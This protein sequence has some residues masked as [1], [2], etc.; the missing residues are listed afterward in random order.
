MQLRFIP[1][2]SGL[3]P[4]TD[5]DLQP[6]TGADG[7]YALRSVERPG[8]RLFVLD[9]ARYLPGYR[10]ELPAVLP[11]AAGAE[12]GH[13]SAGAEA[14]RTSADGE[15]GHTNA[16][17][18]AGHTSSGAAAGHGDA[19]AEAGRTNADG[20]AGH[21]NAG[22]VAGRAGTGAEG[23]AAG[24]GEGATCAGAHGEAGEGDGAPRLLVIV[25]PRPGGPTVNL[26]AP[27]VVD[28]AN[29]TARQVVLADDVARARA[30]LTRLAPTA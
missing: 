9:P 24:G 11:P 21:T 16:D 15:A 7:L 18:E 13:T 12:A 29:G 28:A 30:P 6:V 23:H 10:P 2:L 14:G 5:Y 27:L 1:P 8:I 26:L 17:G 19:R 3:E 25:T 4:L 20:E 22:T